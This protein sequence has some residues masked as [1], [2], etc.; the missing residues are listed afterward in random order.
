M[1][2]DS[3]IHDCTNLIEHEGFSTIIWYTYTVDVV[4]QAR[5]SLSTWSYGH[6]CA[7]NASTRRSIQKPPE[8]ETPR[9]RAKAPVLVP[10]R[11]VSSSHLNL[12][13]A[14]QMEGTSFQKMS[15]ITWGMEKKLVQCDPTEKDWFRGST[16][17]S[18]HNPFQSALFFFPSYHHPHPPPYPE[19]W[20]SPLCL[21][22]RTSQETTRSNHYMHQRGAPFACKRMAM[23]IPPGSQKAILTNGVKSNMITV[24]ITVYLWSL[25][26]I[27]KQWKKYNEYTMY[28]LYIYIF[29]NPFLCSSFSSSDTFSAT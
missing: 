4:V 14:Q 13:N 27:L 23:C 22:E 2:I 17:S 28:I 8:T 9:K 25:Y 3:Y 16:P 5:T 29:Y 6:F 10:L 20:A 19:S 24:L 12:T 15:Q 11:P 26:L 18:G 7:G 21:F 1:V